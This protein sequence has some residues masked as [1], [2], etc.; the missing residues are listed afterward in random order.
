MKYILIGS[1]WLIAAI[2]VG[3]TG[4]VA[5]L[6]P[7]VPQL[8]L[9]AM[10]IGLIAIWLFSGKFR[11][12]LKNLGWRPVVSLHLT[13]FVGFYFLF[14]YRQGQLPF[15]FAVPGGIGDIII[16][17]LAIAL[18]AVPSAVRRRP[19]LLSVWNMLGLID[20]LFV[21][22]TASRL[23][24]GNPMSMAALLRFP[25][26]LLPTFLVPLIIASHLWLLRWRPDE[27]RAV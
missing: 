10:T 20:I 21:V 22:L 25:L 24:M 7:P 4:S 2:L 12:W 19:L 15:A 5:Q 16:A 26:S 27:E 11:V 1:S 23:A 14:L 13:R 17:A 18:L 6:R 3:A 8:V 9:I